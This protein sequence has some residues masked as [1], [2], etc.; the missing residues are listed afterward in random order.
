MISI[1][2]GVGGHDELIRQRWEFRDCAFLFFLVFR[3][4]THLSHES[5]RGSENAWRGLCFFSPLSLESIHRVDN[6]ISAIMT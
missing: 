6:S 2:T 5:F 1:Y 4:G 3:P